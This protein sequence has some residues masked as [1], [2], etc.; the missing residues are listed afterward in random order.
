VPF[1]RSAPRFP[2][3]GEREQ[4]R[5]MLND[6]PANRPAPGTVGDVYERDNGGQDESQG[7]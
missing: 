2:V 3:F 5:Q 7:R 6:Q 1:F 4:A